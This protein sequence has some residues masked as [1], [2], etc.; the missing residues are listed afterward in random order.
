MSATG[1]SASAIAPQTVPPAPAE[2]PPPPPPPPGV[3]TPPIPVEMPA[4]RPIE[5]LVLEQA[6]PGISEPALA[7][8]LP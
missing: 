6:E 5:P 8:P 2:V 3:E 4:D 7:V 1:H